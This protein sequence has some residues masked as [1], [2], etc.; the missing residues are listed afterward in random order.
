ME[1]LADYRCD[2]GDRW[3]PWRFRAEQCLDLTSRLTGCSDG[4][5]EP[6]KKSLGAEAGR[7]FST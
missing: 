7:W 1:G 4:W 5:V 3:S 2:F 6:C